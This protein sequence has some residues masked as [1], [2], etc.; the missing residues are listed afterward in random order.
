MNTKRFFAATFFATVVASLAGCTTQLLVR[1]VPKDAC[2]EQVT[3]NAR[4]FTGTAQ[5]DDAKAKCYHPQGQVYYL[6]RTEH[7]VTLER[8]LTQCEIKPKLDDLVREWFP[9]EKENLESLIEKL[10]ESAENGQHVACDK[11]EEAKHP[12]S[13]Q[14]TRQRL[15][16]AP[17]TKRFGDALPF[18]EDLTANYRPDCKKV[19]RKMLADAY[20]KTEQELIYNFLSDPVFLSGA[21]TGLKCRIERPSSLLSI[22]PLDALN[23]VSDCAQEPD[24]EKFGDV[25]LTVLM[26]ATLSAHMLPDTSQAY[27]IDYQGMSQSSKDT[28]YKVSKYPNG[29]LKSVN[30]I[31]DDKTDEV[32]SSTVRGVLQLAAVSSGFPV[33]FP[34]RPSPDVKI[35]IPKPIHKPLSFAEW[36]DAH[37][38][39]A[40]PSNLC[41]NTTMQ[42]LRQRAALMDQLETLAKQIGQKEAAANKALAT[43][44]EET[45]K[46]AELQIQHDALPKGDE[47]DQIAKD[48]ATHKEAATNG[49][50]SATAANK[51]KAALEKEQAETNAKLNSVRKTLT[52][53]TTQLLYEKRNPDADQVQIIGHLEAA[54]AWFVP[55]ILKKYC[56]FEKTNQNSDICTEVD[57]GS[58]KVLVPNRLMAW[59][60]RYL[61]PHKPSFP[62]NVPTEGLVYREPVQGLLLVCQES[63]CLETD[64]KERL[65]DIVASPD[66][67]VLITPADFPQL[68]VLASLPLTNRAF[69][70]NSITATF[71]PT[72]SLETLEYKSNARAAAAA[73]AFEGSA[74]DILTFAEAKKGA[75]KNDLVTKKAEVDAE[76]ALL[77][78]EKKRAEAKKA[79]DAVL[80]P[81]PP[82]Q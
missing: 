46:A 9:A 45:D 61:A 37:P 38:G 40:E 47:K 13:P 67:T 76:T 12:E 39:F 27:S 25:N 55:E 60:A 17:M 31:I 78:A 4:T 65:G 57:L 56:D 28:E 23:K 22:N 34:P 10:N 59:A 21:D 44:A 68:G 51:E 81:P 80:N 8:E 63:E 20:T 75:K 62:Q 7:L 24:G 74:G 2:L 14:Q 54:R 5:E 71:S 48:I 3:L 53:T 16:N 72:G 1:P 11:K 32:I 49:T 43:A 36:L 70:N 35:S 6:P 77:E 33:T 19:N 79:L 50:K 58:E 66:Q 52:L 64:P 18:I 30:S 82:A 26:R 15:E 29:T 73:K 69:Q 42:R 41:N